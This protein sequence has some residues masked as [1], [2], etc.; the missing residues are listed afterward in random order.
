MAKQKMDALSRYNSIRE[1]IGSEGMTDER[2]T[3][4][5]EAKTALVEQCKTVLS[6][7]L[8]AQPSSL[9]ALESGQLP[10]ADAIGTGDVAFDFD[11]DDAD[12][13]TAA[14]LFSLIT[15]E[16]PDS[17]PELAAVIIAKI[18]RHKIDV[19]L[20]A[21]PAA[22]SAKPAVKKIRRVLPPEADLLAETKT[23][24]ERALSLRHSN[25]TELTSYLAGN[26]SSYAAADALLELSVVD[27]SQAQAVLDQMPNERIEEMTIGHA[28]IGRMGVFNI[29]KSERI[30]SLVMAQ[31]END[32]N[33]VADFTDM[34]N[35]TAAS[36]LAMMIED[37]DD[38]IGVLAH[39]THADAGVIDDILKLEVD[40]P[41]G[42]AAAHHRESLAAFWKEH[43]DDVLE[44]MRDI[45]WDE[46]EAAEAAKE[47][48]E[49]EVPVPVAPVIDLNQPVDLDLI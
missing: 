16:L 22:T 36:L 24:T 38:A 37:H 6:P 28:T 21:A 33:P 45:E 8:V 32:K 34:N 20:G 15:V 35:M 2:E 31:F 12:S 18:A 17:D 25:T 27:A 11:H 10:L 49:I 44:R 41:D 14:E 43:R 19:I 29:M 23:V 7:K 40:G 47:E 42:E 1:E 13:M 30:V 3:Q 48:E 4:L 46:Q 26:V 9:S 39:L 5:T